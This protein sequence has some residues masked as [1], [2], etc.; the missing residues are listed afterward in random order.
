MDNLIDEVVY[1]AV[2]TL[3]ENRKEAKRL[4]YNK[5]ISKA[6]WFEQ[7]CT[8]H[9]NIGRNSGKTRH[10]AEMAKPEDLIV[11]RNGT[12][13]FIEGSSKYKDNL[14]FLVPHVSK[15]PIGRR[16]YSILKDCQ[17]VFVDEPKITLLPYKDLSEFYHSFMVNFNEPMFIMLGE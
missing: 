9:V 7:F 2:K 17:I 8:V 15:I 13:M 5:A 11:C 3:L 14:T 1:V 16:Y 6:Q 4:E 12:R 10:I